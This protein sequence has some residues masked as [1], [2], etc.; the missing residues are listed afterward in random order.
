MESI[1]SNMLEHLD[2]IKMSGYER[3][4]AKSHMH[5]AAAIVEMLL[6]GPN[7]KVARPTQEQQAAV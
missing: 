6:G 4:R 5:T 3:A 7:R 2:T 1:Y